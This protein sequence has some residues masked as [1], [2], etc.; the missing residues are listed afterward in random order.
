MADLKLQALDTEDLKVIS[1]HCQDAI[2]RVA[3]LVYE[4]RERRFALLCNRFDWHQASR[5]RSWFFWR[6]Y[7]RRQAG[8]RFEGV[9]R[10]RFQGFQPADGQ[11]SPEAAL[12]LLAITFTPD[13]EA[14]PSGHITLSFGGGA[15]LRLDVDCIEAELRDLGAV[16]STDKKP[17]HGPDR[18]AETEATSQ[19]KI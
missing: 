12:T 2:V 13:A 6:Q 7:A 18:V 1:A 16:W 8:L 10:V 4:P 19:T 9:R 14:S 15:T 5:R 3:D 11:K 17:D